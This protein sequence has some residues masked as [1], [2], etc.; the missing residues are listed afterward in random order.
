M[1]NRR[2]GQ[3]RVLSRVESRHK[4]IGFPSDGSPEKVRKQREMVPAHEVTVEGR[5]AG[6][7][8]RYF[9]LIIG[10]YF[11]I[12]PFLDPA[13]KVM[14]HVEFLPDDGTV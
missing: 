1:P 8:K 11:L 9:A 5:S 6:E 7:L 3:D 14:F 10:I 4:Q 2:A 13:E 12:L